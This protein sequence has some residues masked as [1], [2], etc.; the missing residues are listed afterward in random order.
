MK[1]IPYMRDDG[2]P[3]F[4]DSE[5]LG[6]YD[7]MCDEGTEPVV[8]CSAPMDKLSFLQYMKRS[9]VLFHFIFCDSGEFVFGFFWISRVSQKKGN[10]HFCFFDGCTSLERVTCAKSIIKKMFSMK[11]SDGSNSFD[12][13]QGMVPCSN[14]AALGFVRAVGGE[15]TESIPKLIYDKRSGGNV[16]GRY[17]FYVNGGENG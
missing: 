3:N 2:I 10:L 5:I 12:L 15:V 7:R 11:E 17:C 9:E 8:F 13:L 4:K 16:A 14:M 1:V 6:L